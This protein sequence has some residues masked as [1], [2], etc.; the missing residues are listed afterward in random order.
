[1]DEQSEVVKRALGYPYA[2][3]SHS[4][5]QAGA[6]TLDLGAVEVD[7]ATRVPLLAYGSNAAPEVLARKLAA[8]PDPVPV[9]RMV[10]R[11]FDVVYSAHVSRYGAVPATLSRSPGTEVAA[12]VA[13]LTAEQLRLVSATEPNYELAR[14]DRPSCTLE[15]GEAPDELRV[16][17]SRHGA[18][19]LD[20]SEI[21]LGA[22]EA[23]GRR[24]PAMSQREVLERV[25]AALCPDRTLEEFVSLSLSGPCPPLPS[26]FRSSSSTRGRNSSP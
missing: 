2:I 19:S 26:A 14:F 15:G 7:L 12:S 22:I 18:L 16:Y 6:R 11:D 25:R 17:V 20:G 5:V 23:H 4:F 13:Y 9:V 24:L 3:P 21:A 8:A 10:L 1:M